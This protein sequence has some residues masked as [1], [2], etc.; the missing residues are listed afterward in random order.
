MQLKK[1]IVAGLFV[2]FLAGL[3]WP[4][5]RPDLYVQALRARDQGN[6]QQAI[7]LL[8]QLLKKQPDSADA[9]F[10][11]GLLYIDTERWP[12]AEQE[13]RKFVQ[14]RPDSLEGH[15]NLAAIYAHSGNTE[16]LGREL[17]SISR[18]KPG[19]AH[20]NAADYYLTLA[21]RALW[22]SFRTAPASERP[23]IAAKLD[24]I[25]SA[26]PTGEN[27]FIQGSMAR[28]QG[29]AK[30]AHESY[31]RAAEL[32]PDYRPEQLLNHAKRLK[33]DG[34]LDQALDEV[35]AAL[36]IGPASEDSE[37]LAGEIL[38]KQKDFAGALKHLEA[39]TASAGSSFDYLSD[40]A[41]ALIGVGQAEKAISYLESALA[42]KS[43]P[44]LQK[45]LAEA[46]KANGDYTKAAVEYE[47]LLGTEP[48]PTWV[49]QEIVK[50]TK[51]KLQAAESSNRVA[52]DP[53][54]AAKPIVRVPGALL[55]LPANKR[56]AVVDKQS[57][58]LLLYRG[59]PQGLELERTFACSTGAQGGEK[60]EQ[61]DSKTPE[62]IYLFRTILPGNRLPQI[63]GKMAITLDYPNAYDRLEG[64]GGDGIWVHATN[65]P[66]RPYLPNKTRGCV[67]ISNEDIQELS[68]LITLKQT[69]LVVLS[70]LSYENDS[71]RAA[72]LKSLETFLADWSGY[73]EH[74]QLD[75]YISEYSSRFRNGNQDLK[76]WRAYKEAVFS[77][78]G[79]IQLR[80]EPESVI[81]Y[82]KYAVLTFRQEYRS[83]R[84]TSEGT[85]RLFV[86]QE[87]GAWKIIA[88]EWLEP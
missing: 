83:Q 40:M 36:V 27:C 81:R 18:V 52:G 14:F 5:G 30:L 57:Q 32:D 77:R 47:K 45:K 71:D 88:E 17:Q 50:L 37:L 13:F 8:R 44:E 41:E 84:L 61:G 34:A 4:A 39:I 22:H 20:L 31:A 12:Q 16:M 74:K 75:K 49:R 6:K 26:A 64:K 79:Q 46:Y 9:H 55:L 53:G 54:S 86:V 62:G 43:V 24:K 25:A 19:P 58:T 60:I 1:C 68:E 70:K 87:N 28:V 15:S 38:L 72:A 65:E 21:V 48:N 82:D 66:I 69:P 59:S 2:C 7:D 85:K 51:L 10:Q 67:V 42:L 33:N 73:W 23:A 11:L 63:Y 29:D 35:L 80:T 56:C 78:A 3:T 76:A